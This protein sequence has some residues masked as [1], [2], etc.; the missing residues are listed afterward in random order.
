MSGDLA[1][2]KGRRVSMIWDASSNLSN[3]YKLKMP[4]ECNNVNVAMESENKIK[5]KT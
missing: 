4:L 1:F 3:Q 5:L 2:C